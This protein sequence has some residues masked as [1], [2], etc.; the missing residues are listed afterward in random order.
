MVYTVAL[1]NFFCTLKNLTSLGVR[2]RQMPS[3]KIMTGL[4]LNEVQVSTIWG[5][6][7]EVLEAADVL[8]MTQVG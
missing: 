2:H 7:D 6:L 1:A 4:N 3:A 8:A 5:Q